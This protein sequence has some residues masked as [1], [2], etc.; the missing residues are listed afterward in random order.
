MPWGLLLR[1]GAPI[2]MAISLWTWGYSAG[3]ASVQ[4]AWNKERAAQ[5]EINLEAERM[6]RQAE[7]ARFTAAKEAQDANQRTLHAARAARD[8]ARDELGRLL[9]AAPPPGAAASDP[10]AAVRAAA[11]AVPWD[12]FSDCARALQKMAGEADELE[13]KLIGWQAWWAAV[14]PAP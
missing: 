1:I 8:A 14:K 6:V 10:G 3:H 5:T 11:A 7:R 12:V 9:D 2:A 4:R 13:A